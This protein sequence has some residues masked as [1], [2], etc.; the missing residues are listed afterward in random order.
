MTNTRRGGGRAAHVVAASADPLSMLIFTTSL[1]GT[2][3]VP[4]NDSHE[5]DN[6]T[7]REPYG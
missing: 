4:D 3:H 1:V 6:F 7:R 5:Q 2:F